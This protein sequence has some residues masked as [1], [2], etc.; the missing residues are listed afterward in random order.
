MSSE[1]RIQNFPQI[2]IPRP[3]GPLGGPRGRIQNGVLAMRITLRLY[4]NLRRYADAKRENNELD[5][6]AGMTIK[7]LL[8]SF[9]L[10]EYDWWMSAVNERVVEADTVLQENDM[11]EVFEPVGGG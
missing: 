5:V 9:G 3:P 7:Q 10:S 11:V 8:E 1:F 4:G 6:A 2:Q